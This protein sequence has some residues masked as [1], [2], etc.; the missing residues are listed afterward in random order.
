MIKKENET[1]NIQL[2]CCCGN[3]LT[4][5]LT[6]VWYYINLTCKFIH[7]TIDF[8]FSSYFLSFEFYSSRNL[9]IE[10]I[11]FLILSTYLSNC[12]LRCISIGECYECIASICAGHWIHH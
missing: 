7:A 1:R 6:K 4:T 11:V 8:V 10:R 5:G 9:M 2:A 3:L 12:L